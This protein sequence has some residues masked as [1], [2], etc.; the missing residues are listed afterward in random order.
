MPLGGPEPVKQTLETGQLAVSNLF[1]AL[2]AN[3]PTIGINVP[4]IRDGKILY[5]LEMAFSPEVLT[6]LLVEQGLSVDRVGSIMDARGV[7]IARTVDPQRYVGRLGSSEY[8]IQIEK[9]KESVADGINVAGVPTHYAFVRSK[10]T[11]WSTAVA[12]PQAAIAGPINQSIALFASAAAVFLL[13][14][15][16]AALVLGRRIV[17]PVSTLA[18]SADAMLRGEA[19]KLKTPV[20]REITELRDALLIAGQVARDATAEREQ[21]LAEHRIRRLAEVSAALSETIDFDK[22]LNRLAD[23]MVP[24]QADWCVV[25]LIYGPDLCSR[26][27]ASGGGFPAA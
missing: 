8:R 9:S 25:D 20:G 26:A 7:V 22:A 12:V 4:V 19:V 3:L 21:R 27:S 15:L 11:G 2:D 10:L 13:L 5:S 1:V 17:S 24:D 23:L 6:E 16:G 14:G 18:G